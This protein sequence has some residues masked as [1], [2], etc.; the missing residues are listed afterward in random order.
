MNYNSKHTLNFQD[1]S[2]VDDKFSVVGNMTLA[3]TDKICKWNPQATGEQ[4]L[5]F[6]IRDIWYP[7]LVLLNQFSEGFSIVDDAWM[8]ARVSHHGKVIVQ[9][10]SV[11][12]S[13]C[14]SSLRRSFTQPVSPACVGLSLNLSVRRDILP[15]RLAGRSK[16]LQC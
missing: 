7:S 11:F 8:A 4:S 1:V 15:V 13:T 3:W 14:Q 5:V 12:H 10:A 16:S 9:L 2:E 6:P